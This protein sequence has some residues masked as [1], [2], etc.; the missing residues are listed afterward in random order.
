MYIYSAILHQDLYRKLTKFF[1]FIIPIHLFP[2]NLVEDDVNLVIEE[3]VND[4][5]IEKSDTEKETYES[6]EDPKFLQ[7]YDDGGIFV[8]W[9]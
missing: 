5:D 8:L 3:I 4:E 1:R 6:I 9:M 2:N 7:D